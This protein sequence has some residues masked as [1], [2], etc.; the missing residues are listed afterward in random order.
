MND[1]FRR[2]LLRAHMGR[3]GAMTTPALGQS[4]T[5][6]PPQTRDVPGHEPTLRQG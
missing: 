2:S 4:Q 6:K 1:H 3:Q 5:V